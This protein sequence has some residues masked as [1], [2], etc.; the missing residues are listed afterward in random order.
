MVASVLHGSYGLTNEDSALD[1]KA[2]EIAAG[3]RVY[4]PQSLPAAEV[5]DYCKR[6]RSSYSSALVFQGV[7][8]GERKAAQSTLQALQEEGMKV[9]SAVWTMVEQADEVFR[10]A[11]DR[12]QG[13]RRAKEVHWMAQ[14]SA[15]RARAYVPVPPKAVGSNHIDLRRR[16]PTSDEPPPMLIEGDLKRWTKSMELLLVRKGLW[17]QCVNPQP[18]STSHVL[19]TILLSEWDAKAAEAARII[20]SYINPNLLSRIPA[21]RWEDYQGRRGLTGSFLAEAHRMLPH[22]IRAASIWSQHRS[23]AM[24]PSFGQTGFD[25]LR[26]KVSDFYQAE[27]TRS[28]AE[29]MTSGYYLLEQLKSYA[30]P[31]RLM[32]LPPELRLMIYECALVEPEPI[33]V[34]DVNDFEVLL[35]A[36]RPETTDANGWEAGL[37]MRWYLKIGDVYDKNGKFGRLL[38]DGRK[39]ADADIVRKMHN[40]AVTVQMRV[41]HRNHRMTVPA[42]YQMVRFHAQHS[43]LNGLEVTLPANVS[44]S[45][46]FA[47]QY[48]DHWVARL[49]QYETKGQPSTPT[50]FEYFF[51]N[52]ELWN[53]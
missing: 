23:L 13:M 51:N 43:R 44:T 21:E 11:D 2:N 49:R 17:L 3:F 15:D 28:V 47:K 40:L 19:F 5:G 33:S 52:K 29:D 31:F 1:T 26:S 50:M 6:F 45:F 30:K 7:A 38:R 18:P 9:P 27:E 53:D 35:N 34:L 4:A 39:V 36:N 41:V 25:D 14:A 48:L 10:A 12:V 20:K 46:V 42:Q 22:E 32:D 16:V 37:L 8:F 24:T